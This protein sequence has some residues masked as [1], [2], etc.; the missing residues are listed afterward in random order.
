MGFFRLVP[1][2][3][4]A[5]PLHLRRPWQNHRRLLPHCLRHHQTQRP[6]RHLRHRDHQPQRRCPPLSRRRHD[7]RGL[8][9]REMTV[10]PRQDG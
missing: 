9:A 4:L 3:L 8:R 6:A 1:H 10:R 2:D 5:L 7:R